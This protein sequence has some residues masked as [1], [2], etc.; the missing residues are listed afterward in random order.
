MIGGAFGLLQNLCDCECAG[1]GQSP[2]RYA[3]SLPATAVEVRPRTKTP[4]KNPRKK[5]VPA[6][7]LI[8]GLIECPRLSWAL[9]E[10]TE[11]TSY[12]AGAIV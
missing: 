4:T 3:S 11:R 9:I 12:C 2:R 6:N 10:R 7:P 1:G 8:V 5:K